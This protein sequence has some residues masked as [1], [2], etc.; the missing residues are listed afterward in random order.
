MIL[1]LNAPYVNTTD[2]T[3]TTIYTLTIPASTTVRLVTEVIARRTGGAAGTAEDGAG[4]T[5]YGTYKNVAGAATLIGAVAKTSPVPSE[6]QATMDV[7]F[8][9]SGATVLVQ[10]TGVVN[11][12]FT[13]SMPQAT[14]TRVS[15]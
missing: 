8:V 14:A 3:P 7:N 5:L 4:Y 6:S 15:Q 1:P 12:N 10:V 11:N 2:A 9:A 13:W